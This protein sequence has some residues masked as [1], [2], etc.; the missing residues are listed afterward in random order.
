MPGDGDAAQSAFENGLA[1]TL[2]SRLGDLNSS[3]RLTVI[4]TSEMRDKHITTIQGTREQFGANLVLTLNV[5]RAAGLARVNYAVVDTASLQQLHSGTI[6][7]PISNPFALQD[8]VFESVA[9]AMQLHPSLQDRQSR[10]APG[11]LQPAAYDYYL[12]G[13]G[14]L[15]DYIKPENVENAIQVF[16]H[17]LE[18]DPNF[19]AANAGLGEAYWSKYQLTHDKQWVDASMKNCQ[20]AAELDGALA[21]AHICLGRVFTSTGNYK[22]ALEQYQEA[23]KLEPAGDTAQ[24]GLAY[25]YERLDRLDDAEKTYKQAIAM[26]PNY[27]ATYNWLGLFYQRHARYEDASSM[28]SQVISLVPDSFTGYSNLGGI[29]VLQGRYADS[30]PLLRKLLSIRPTADASSNLATAYFQMHRY[31]ESSVE[32]EKAVKLDEKDYQMWGNL[33]DAYYWS[34]GQRPQARQAYKRAIALGEERLRVN[35]RDFEILGYVAMYHAMC[36]ERKPAIENLDAAL[37]LNPKSPDLLF[38]AGIVYQQLGE[39]SLALDSLER[40]V[41][42]G[43]SPTT[44]RDT[45]NFDNLRDNTR[46]LRLIER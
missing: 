13:R 46:F 45:P 8:R 43:I 32:F 25:T 39:T 28:Y 31:P 7:E 35:P 26:R 10:G 34:P 15:Q 29:C 5:Q 41:A 36:E 42:G 4:P 12:Q 14:Y 6:T 2:N 23:V 40:A 1:D 38:T 17:A 27:W 20:K 30:I 24:G 9:T 18:T 22:K 33:G 19:A 16:S 11:T 37:R 3:G 44:L 21:S